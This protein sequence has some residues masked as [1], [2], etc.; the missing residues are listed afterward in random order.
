[1]FWYF[2]IGI[3]VLYVVYRL[4]GALVFPKIAKHR[5][6]KFRKKFLEENPQIK[7]MNDE[8]DR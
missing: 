1:M 7:N 2:I 5:Q 6:E 8:N 4:C 3:I